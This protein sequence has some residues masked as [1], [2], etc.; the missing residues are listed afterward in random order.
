MIN[1]NYN[2][3]IIGIRLALFLI[4]Y[5][6]NWFIV[7]LV[8]RVMLTT[9]SEW[10]EMVTKL[11]VPKEWKGLF[12]DLFLSENRDWLKYVCIYIYMY[13]SFTHVYYLCLM[14]RVANLCTAV[15]LVHGISDCCI[16]FL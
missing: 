14:R 4:V 11:N 2:P 1:Q 8:I 15:L 7:N 9:S 6:S 13:M 16:H 5:L 3:L 12:Y 10:G